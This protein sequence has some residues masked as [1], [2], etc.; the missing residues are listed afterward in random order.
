M[1]SEL[2]A[3]ER[4][5][6]PAKQRTYLNVIASEAARLTRLINNVLDFARLERGEKK[7]DFKSL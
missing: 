2:L 3:E 4:V 1:F 5:A 6:D 7:Y